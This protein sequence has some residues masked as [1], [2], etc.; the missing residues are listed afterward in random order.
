ME[1]SWKLWPQDRIFYIFKIFYCFIFAQDN[2]KINVQEIYF[3]KLSQ[4]H[5]MNFL[6]KGTSY[7]GV[8]K[9]SILLTHHKSCIM[10][11]KVFN[12]KMIV[13]FYKSQWRKLIIPVTTVN[14]FVF[15]DLSMVFATSKATSNL[16]PLI[17]TNVHYYLIKILLV[18]P[19][20]FSSWFS[21]E[22]YFSQSNQLQP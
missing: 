16:P 1:T 8:G 5:S 7:V 19:L 21:H 15:T 22:R 20:A 17:L 3:T 10:W 4:M 9:A 14:T 18:Y 11:P 13:N 12:K 6:V 2:G